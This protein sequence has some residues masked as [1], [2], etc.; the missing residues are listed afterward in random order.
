MEGWQIGFATWQKVEENEWREAP[1]PGKLGPSDS[2]RVWQV[3]GHWLAAAAAERHSQ[4]AVD[5]TS[6]RYQ[7][8]MEGVEDWVKSGACEWTRCEVWLGGWIERALCQGMNAFQARQSAGRVLDRVVR[9]WYN[10]Q[11]EYNWPSRG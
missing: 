10:R 2:Y 6:R 7:L 4:S 11:F 1:S 3:C 9:K 5:Q 8:G